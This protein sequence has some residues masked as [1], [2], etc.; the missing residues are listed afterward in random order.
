MPAEYVVD[1]E[2]EFGHKAA[3]K[4]EEKDRHALLRKLILLPV[5][6][7]ISALS[8]LFSAVNYDPLGLDVLNAVD[9]GEHADTAFPVLKTLEPNGPAPGYGVLDEDYIIYQNNG[10]SSFVHAGAAYNTPDVTISGLTYDAA[11]N[12]L[13]MKD[14]KGD[15]LDVNMMGNGFTIVLEGDNDLGMLHLWGFYYGGSVTITGTGTLTLN[16][17][18]N[19]KYGLAIDA[20]NSDS[21]IMIDAGVKLDIKGTEA[22]IAVFETTLDKAIYYKA[23]LTMT[24]GVRSD[25]ETV[26]GMNEGS[27]LFTVYGE[28]KAPAKQVIFE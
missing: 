21:C 15:A 16:A 4:P 7:S 11:T 1:P 25:G 27:Y 8:I 26:E 14:F 23:P 9:L 2:M 13:T 19:Y 22:A 10:A 24:G 3:A 12:T 18:E 28:D 5:A 20:E 17:T 6:A